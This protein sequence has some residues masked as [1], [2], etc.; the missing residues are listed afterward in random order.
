MTIAF[1][2]NN[3]AFLPEIDAYSRFFS[4][5]HIT[6]ESVNKNEVA[7]VHR[8]V[9]WWMMG[10]DFTKLKEGIFKIHEYCSS[11]MPPWRWWK[12]RGKSFFNAQPDFR[13]F[14][15]EYVRKAFYFHDRIPFGYRDMGVPEQWLQADP[16][17]YE[18]E[19]DFVYTGDI[20][21]VREPE[22]L[23]NCFSTG[24]MKNRTLL[25][26]AKDYEHLQAAYAGFENIVFTGPFPYNKMDS[27]ILKARFGINYMINKEP[28]NHQ[29]S[30]KLLEYAALGL[31]V[32][33][34]KYAWVEKFQQQYGGNFFYLEPDLSNFSWEQVH[35][36]PFSKPD[37]QALTWENRI[38][39]SGVLEFLASKFPEIRF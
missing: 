8:D 19:Y 14:L 16:F 15:N 12:N 5:Y 9:E 6:C 11:S 28:F 21:P 25:L 32:I 27:N 4:G 23:L 13:L 38:R 22:L 2:H 7:R 39:N 35:N 24:A 10:T 18:R 3:K 37:L 29:T 20:S 31:P 36:F 17:L 1:V 33:T 30:T 26:I 34:T